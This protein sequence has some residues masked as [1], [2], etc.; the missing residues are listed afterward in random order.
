MTY[1]EALTISAFFWMMKREERE[2][3]GRKGRA[4]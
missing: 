3:G 2:K 4:A 1:N